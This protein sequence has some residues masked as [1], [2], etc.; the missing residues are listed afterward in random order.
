M[1]L[2]KTAHHCARYIIYV[3]I[4]NVRYAASYD[5]VRRLHLHEA[6]NLLKHLIDGT[7]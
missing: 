1:H 7:S 3:H 4:S 5:T 2:W 6:R